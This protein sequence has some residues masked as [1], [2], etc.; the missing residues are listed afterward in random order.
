[1]SRP[2]LPRIVVLASGQGT[3]LQ[4]LIEAARS[5][6]LPGRIAAVF[7]DRE[8]ARALA[9][10]RTAGIT[11]RFVG[12][13][14]FADRAAYE[15]ELARAIAAVDPRVIVLAGFM[16]VLGPAFVHRFEGRMINLH[17]SLLPKYRGL[18]TH[19][20][21]LASGDAVHGATV[22]FVTEELDAGPPIVQYRIPVRSGDTADSL[23]A[24]VH[25]GEYLILPRAT[26]W[27]A[28]GRLELRDG[29]AWLDGRR[30]D[31]PLVV[32]A[33]E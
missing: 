30:L 12:P 25:A 32:E 26:A 31:E 24:R 13:R 23:A 11:A 16:R 8:E 33:E 4:A 10:A 9:R 5:G 22:H 28:A 2:E 15:A 21:A 29:A 14:S 19:A 1:L 7:S 17:P 27:L 18:D 20:R 3:N 6:T